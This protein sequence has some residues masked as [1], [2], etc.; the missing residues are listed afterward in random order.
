MD[1]P[2]TITQV[3]TTAE[4]STLDADLI[5]MVNI[6]CSETQSRPQENINKKM[7][8]LFFLNKRVYAFGVLTPVIIVCLELLESEVGEL[9]FSLVRHVER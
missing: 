8:E 9:N 6:H 3:F 2:S 7:F 5:P 1:H 4:I